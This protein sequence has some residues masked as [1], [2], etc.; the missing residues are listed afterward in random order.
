MRDDHEPGVEVAVDG[1]RCGDGVEKP[2]AT[3]GVVER[4]H[5]EDRGEEVRGLDEVAA[6]VHATIPLPSSSQRSNPSVP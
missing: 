3:P 2:V 1:C 5:E 6:G 4:V